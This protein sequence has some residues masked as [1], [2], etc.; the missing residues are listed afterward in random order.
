MDGLWLEQNRRHPVMQC[1]LAPRPPAAAP[2]PAPRSS[3]R[4][5]R[6]AV[7]LRR[8]ISI[9][10]VNVALRFRLV[11][12]A[13]AACCLLFTSGNC[14]SQHRAVCELWSRSSQASAASRLA[15]HYS[16][17]RYRRSLAIK[18]TRAASGSRDAPS[19]PSAAGS[20]HRRPQLQ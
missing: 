12:L 11:S 13:A 10:C 6:P 17:K 4:L 8:Q 19:T 2:A 3:L 16:L 20:R 15:S 5:G 1:A 9:L 7:P 14:R 18:L